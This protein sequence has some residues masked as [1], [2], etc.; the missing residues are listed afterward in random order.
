VEI[1]KAPLAAR[2]GAGLLLER[3]TSEGYTLSLAPDNPQE[4]RV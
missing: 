2:T 1:S 3:E 4:I